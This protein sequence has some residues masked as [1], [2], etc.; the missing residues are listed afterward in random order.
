VPR[1][2]G[3]ACGSVPVIRFRSNQYFTK[4]KGMVILFVINDDFITLVEFGG[5]IAIVN[6][7]HS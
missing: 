1:P 2:Q 5:S 6:D 7:L 4:I 3:W